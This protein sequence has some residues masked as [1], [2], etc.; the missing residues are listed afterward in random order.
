MIE[1]DT[2]VNFMC[3]GPMCA[4]QDSQYK[5]RIYDESGMRMSIHAV[6]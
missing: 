5:I 1:L 6:E 3:M 4:F 2:L